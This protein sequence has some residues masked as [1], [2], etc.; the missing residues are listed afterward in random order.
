MK[1]SSRGAH[2][3]TLWS[4]IWR[5]PT[6]KQYFTGEPGWV[7]SLLASV[8]SPIGL[9]ALHLIESRAASCYF[10]ETSH[11]WL[12][13]FIQLLN[14]YLCFVLIQK[15]SRC[16]VSP[17]SPCVGCPAFHF[18]LYMIIQ[19]YLIK[20]HYD[21]NISMK[22]ALC[23]AIITHYNLNKIHFENYFFYEAI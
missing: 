12:Q 10:A 7:W 2:A 16:E 13:Y 5:K 4:T 8:S 22:N 20:N 17:L 3:H 1:E 14:L 11:K 9:L 6:S 23:I 18:L 19:T 15:L 21:Y